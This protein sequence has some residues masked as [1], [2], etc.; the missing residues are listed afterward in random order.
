MKLGSYCEFN[1]RPIA[2]ETMVRKVD[3]LEGL[4]DRL[5][6]KSTVAKTISKFMNVKEVIEQDSDQKKEKIFTSN[7][8]DSQMGKGLGVTD[9]GTEN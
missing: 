8:I 6:N 7:I 5:M 1:M 9:T 3:L 4:I 2:I